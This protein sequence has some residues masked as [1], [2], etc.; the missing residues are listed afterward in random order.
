MDC[1]AGAERFSWLVAAAVDARGATP[2]KAAAQ[3]PKQD[4]SEAVC[5]PPELLGSTCARD[6]AVCFLHA[7]LNPS[8]PFCTSLV[9]GRCNLV[10]L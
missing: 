2:P 5:P 4:N 10:T 6:T 7:I 1:D 8:R 3:E 9:M